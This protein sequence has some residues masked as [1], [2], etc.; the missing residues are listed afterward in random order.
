MKKFAAWIL[1]LLA[2]LCVSALAE[3]ELADGTY[4][5]DDFTF[6]GGTGR[7]TITCPEITVTGG[8]ATATIA[9][10]SPNYGYVK[11]DGVQYDGVHT[12]DASAFEVPAPLNRE[13]TLVGMTTAMSQPHEIEYRLRIRLDAA[14]ENPAL[15][16]E[17]SLE[18]A[19]AEGF[20]VDYCQGGYVLIDV[21]DSARYLLVPEGAEPPEGLDSDIV[22]LRQPL[23]RVY[24][25]A[26]SAMSLFDRL[27]ALDR[28][29]FSSLE[30]DGWT[31][32][33]A[34]AAME[35]GDILFGGKYSEPVYELLV[36]EDCDLAVES[37]MILHTPKVQETLEALGIPVFID[38]SSYEPHPLGRTE[39]IKLY[40]VL[41]GREA[42]A[43]AFFAEQA[44][45]V[46]G[47]KD[48]GRTGKTVAFFYI[49]TDGSA[50][51]RGATDYV[52]R[53]IEIAGGEYAFA[54]LGEMEG[55]HSSVTLSMEE[56]YAAALDADYLIYNASIDQGVAS[57]EDLMTRSALLADFKAVREGNVYLADRSLYQAMDTVG[58]LIVDLNRMLTGAEDGMTFLHK[59][60]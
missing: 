59:M 54:Y 14:G 22:L 34:A 52:A 26:T 28:I 47:L 45:L 27:D 33:A 44:A 31:V 15:V 29:R 9:F 25:A 16:P 2:L 30:A 39:W 42:E 38:R 5:P 4:I 11:V 1:A 49:N 20:S 41:T 3:G 7:V 35:A 12:E 24:L 37:T 43:A 19:Y 50:V 57:L 32:P 8:R 17:S 55:G 56:F 40:G 6:S 51:V 58:S 60:H 18:L 13:F 21:K 48:F 53:C 36:K 46:E 23:E 10:S